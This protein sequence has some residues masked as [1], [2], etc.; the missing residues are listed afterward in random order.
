MR[1]RG[2]TTA[3]PFVNFKF[4]AFAEQNFNVLLREVHVPSADIHNQR[5]RFDV[6][7]RAELLLQHRAHN[8]FDIVPG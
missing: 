3:K 6:R 7:C 2:P 4:R 8:T 5:I 1:R